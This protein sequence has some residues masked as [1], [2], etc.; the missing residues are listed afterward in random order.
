M[1]GETKRLLK[2]TQFLAADIFLVFFSF[3]YSL[4]HL[5]INSGINT[6]QGIGPLARNCRWVFENLWEFFMGFNLQDGSSSLF[7]TF[8][9]FWKLIADNRQR[10]HLQFH[11]RF[12]KL[13]ISW[14]QRIPILF[15]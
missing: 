2:K 6:E 5:G 12:R 15:S 8:L 1:D 11:L 14:R 10:V 4:L 13:R 7:Y 3:N 9:F